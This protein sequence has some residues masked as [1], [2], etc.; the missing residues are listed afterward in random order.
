MSNLIKDF[1]DARATNTMRPIWQIVILVPLYPIYLL[2]RKFVEI[3]DE[4]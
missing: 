3:M 1:R 4:V 2:A